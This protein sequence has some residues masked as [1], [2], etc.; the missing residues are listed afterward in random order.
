MR[1]ALRFE[2][3]GHGFPDQPYHGAHEC[4]DEDREE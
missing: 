2:Q 4:D 1:L 3:L